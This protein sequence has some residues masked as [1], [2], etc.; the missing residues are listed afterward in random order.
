MSRPRFGDRVRRMND[1]TERF[2]KRCHRRLKLSV[3]LY[4][5]DSR[6]GNKLGQSPR[7]SRDS[8]LAIKL[9][10][11]TILSAAIVTQ[12]FAAATHTIQPLVHYHSIAFMQVGNRAANLLDH[13]GDLMTENLWL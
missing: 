10:L 9:A 4:S 7:Q 5:I 6:N 2:D 8:M 11:V 12:N 13:A 3:D 1:A